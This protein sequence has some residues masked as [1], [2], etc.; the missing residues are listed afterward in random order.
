MSSVSS[1]MEKNSVLVIHQQHLQHQV[2]QHQ[3]QQPLLQLSQLIQQR[4]PLHQLSQ[5]NQQHPHLGQEVPVA[6]TLSQTPG[7]ITFKEL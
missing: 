5:L 6:A 7:L 1:L 2:Q 3:Q 4:Q